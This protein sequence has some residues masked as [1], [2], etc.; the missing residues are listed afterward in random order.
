MQDVNALMHVE[1]S[2]FLLISLALLVV[3]CKVTEIFFSGDSSAGNSKSLHFLSISSH[4]A[5][6][7]LSERS[8]FF[9]LLIM[10]SSK[11]RW[12][13]STGLLMLCCLVDILWSQPSDH[14]SSEM[15]RQHCEVRIKWVQITQI[16]TKRPL[17]SCPWNTACSNTKTL[18]FTEIIFLFLI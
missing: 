9:T 11:R 8:L 17:Y 14:R 15:N 3:A 16:H 6:L 2:D 7:S 13:K 10:S 12:T 1:V 4:N 18:Y 5:S